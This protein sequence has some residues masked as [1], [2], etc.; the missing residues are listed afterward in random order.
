M[1]FR[2]RVAVL[3]A[4]VVAIAVACVAGS[5]LY[6]ARGQA[7]ES[8][9]SKLRLRA[10]AVIQLSEKFGRLREFDRRMFGISGLK[11]R[12]SIKLFAIFLVKL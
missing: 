1:S 7:V 4:L 2:A 5:F 9:D 8:I 12:Y 6:L 11:I 10:S 3:V